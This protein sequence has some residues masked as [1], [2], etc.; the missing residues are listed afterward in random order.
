LS[1]DTN[2]IK[3]HDAVG[4]SKKNNYTLSYRKLTGKG[5]SKQTLDTI[6]TKFSEKS[7]EQDF[8]DMLDNIDTDITPITE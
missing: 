5:L 4:K 7:P 8:L 2:V 6:S 1:D 3:F